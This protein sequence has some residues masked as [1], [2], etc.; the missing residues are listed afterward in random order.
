MHYV[1]V[2][3]V[4]A[5]WYSRGAVATAYN[6]RLAIATLLLAE[7]IQSKIGNRKLAMLSGLAANLPPYLET[8]LFSSGVVKTILTLLSKTN[9]R[10]STSGV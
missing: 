5:T 8:E 3:K 7:C 1:I 6:C 4:V 9:P 2:L 10:G